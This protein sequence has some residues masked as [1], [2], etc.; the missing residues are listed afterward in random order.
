MQLW[1]IP[2]DLMSKTVGMAIG[3]KMGSCIKIGER[4]WSSEQARFMRV[5]VA[6]EVA[7]PLRRGG[8]IISPEGEKT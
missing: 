2:F 6:L 4:P 3:N 1:G 5:Q 7:V 8:M